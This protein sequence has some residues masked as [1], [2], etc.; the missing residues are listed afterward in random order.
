ML[1]TLKCTHLFRSVRYESCT[2]CDSRTTSHWNTARSSPMYLVALKEPI[3]THSGVRVL[4]ML[5]AA[6]NELEWDM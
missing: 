3:T 5:H 4:R 1:G 6:E 2:L